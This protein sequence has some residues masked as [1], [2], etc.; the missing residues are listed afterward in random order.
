MMESPVWTSVILTVYS[1]MIPFCWLVGG[2]DQ[3]RTNDVELIL[4]ATRSS[5][6]TLGDEKVITVI[7]Y[8]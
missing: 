5:G 1:L 7:T 6:G 4:V 3:K 8:L 2:G